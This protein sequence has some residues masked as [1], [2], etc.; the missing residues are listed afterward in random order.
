MDTDG[1]RSCDLADAQF[2]GLLHSQRLNL[3]YMR[4]QKRLPHSSRCSTS[5]RDGPRRVCVQ[6]ISRTR[7][8]VCCAGFTSTGPSS[9]RA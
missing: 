2:C 1:L 3:F 6:A 4:H 7:S 5:G 9:P 8:F